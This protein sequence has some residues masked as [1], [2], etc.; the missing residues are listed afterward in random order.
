MVLLR[1]SRGDVCTRTPPPLV[2]KPSEHC[3]CSPGSMQ[4]KRDRGGGGAEGGRKKWSVVAHVRA[5]MAPFCERRAVP[6][7][8]ARVSAE[9]PAKTPISTLFDFSFLR[10][11]SCFLDSC[12]QLLSLFARR[13][14][15]S[16]RPQIPGFSHALR[17]KKKTR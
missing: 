14:N 1:A 2:A 8:K 5:F 7:K 10:L 3:K 13:L 4:R 16:T 6:A 17:E 11:L 15:Y 12:V 9:R